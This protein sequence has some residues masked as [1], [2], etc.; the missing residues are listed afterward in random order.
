MASSESQTG[1]Q[2]SPG[3]SQ[4]SHDV[5]HAGIINPDLDLD[6]LAVSFAEDGVLQI[7]Q[8]LRPQVADLLHD[9]LSEQVPWALAYRDHSGPRKLWSEELEAMSEADKNKLDSEIYWPVEQ[10]VGPGSG[11]C[12]SY[13]KLFP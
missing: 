1:A 11:Q 8:G 4:A 3:S 5:V 6:A 12:C 10:Q 9:C 7:E 2:T 13:T